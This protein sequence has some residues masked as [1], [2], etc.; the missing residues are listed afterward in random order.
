MY[1]SRPAGTFGRAGAVWVAMVLLCAVTALGVNGGCAY[2]NTFYNAKQAYKD[3]EEAG[4]NVDQRSWPTAAQRPK[5]SLC[6][7][8]CELLL[9]EHPNSNHVDDALLYRFGGEKEVDSE[10]EVAVERAA[11][12]VPPGVHALLRIAVAKEVDQAPIGQPLESLALGAGV[13]NP[14]G[15]LGG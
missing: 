6:I 10:T 9:E 14:A 15:G 1:W 7:S 4:K 11:P 3:A 5:Y 2:Y 13:K 12:V 8:K